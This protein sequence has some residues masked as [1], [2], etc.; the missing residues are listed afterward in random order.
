LAPAAE[1]LARFVEGLTLH[2]P[3][4]P[5]VSNV[6][7]TWI[8]APQAADPRYWAEHL[9]RPVR[10]SEGIGELWREP[11]RV[12]L[13]IGPGG[14]LAT[15]ALQHPA[16]G[17]GSDPVAVATLRSAYER[18]S[19]QAFL[20]GTFGKLWL[21]GVRVSWRG[22]YAGERRRRV[23]LPAYPFERQRYWIE[24]AAGEALEVSGAA[25]VP[26]LYA[27]AWSRSAPLAAP[28]PEDLAAG[29]WLVFTTVGSR[30]GDGLA[31]RLR[32]A[33]ARVA[34]V[35]PGE[36]FEQR[37]QGSYRLDPHRA[38]DYDAL[39]GALLQEWGAPPDRILHLW[40]A[41][42]SVLDGGEAERFL[43][44]QERGFYS[45]LFLTQ[46]LARWQMDSGRAPEPIRALVVSSG[47]YPVTG[48]DALR[49]ENAPLAALC[50]S[51]SLEMDGVVCRPVDVTGRADRLLGDLLAEALEGNGAADEA[52]AYR[53]G[54]RW[55]RSYAPVPAPPGADRG[56]ALRPGG[57]LVLAGR[58]DPLLA[59][60]A[61]AVAAQAGAILAPAGFETEEELRSALDRIEA[62]SGPVE[63]IIV[64]DV[65]GTEPP[66]LPAAFVTRETS[67]A[68]LAGTAQRL[69]A[70]AA[71]LAGREPAFCL[72]V[73]SLAPAVAEPGKALQGIVDS[74]ADAF[75]GRPFAAGET[76]WTAVSWDRSE[77][78]ETAAAAEVLRRILTQA[79]V[80]RVVVS[81][82]DLG[83]RIRR[84]AEPGAAEGMAEAGPPAPGRTGITLHARP[85]LRN[86]YVEPATDVERSLVEMWQGILGIEKIGI[87]DSFFDLGGDS[88]LATQVFNRIRETYEVDIQLGNFFEQPTAAGLAAFIDSGRPAEGETEADKMA[89]IMDTLDS[90]SPEDIERMLAER[91]TL[92]E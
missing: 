61:A 68:L 48:A 31:G 1:P 22:L 88:L 84:A 39:L 47:L 28:L 71:A 20:L 16:A 82:E 75:A 38:G 89:R 76:P 78:V 17:E 33:G 79:P 3:R 70:L 91:G 6:T 26:G 8:T 72:L 32:E 73:S 21:A 53:N 57:V 41:G 43:V 10:F 54:S 62:A 19:D 15:L 60:A 44:A 7:G 83:R 13:E 77:E 27:P 49:F 63:G 5:Y 45:L 30:L 52:V 51:L 9:V 86:P 24:A 23:E 92:E 90:L 2:A 36:W 58:P 11:G 55:L 14:S 29:R 25:V 80:P 40:T 67:E 50:R 85:N 74:L 81:W 46:S 34:M 87:Q 35:L 59:D 69:S 4:I 42:P 66:P 65:A 18:R 64:A 56:A 12:L 37:A